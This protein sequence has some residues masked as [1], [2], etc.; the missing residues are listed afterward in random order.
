LVS[1]AP[2]SLRRLT[3]D[4]AEAFRAL[5]LE[6]F[7]L[8]PECFRYAPED[9]AHL[10]LDHFARRLDAD[11]VLGL[12]DAETLVGVGGLMAFAGVKVAHKALLYGMYLRAAFRGRGGADLLMAELLA[13][14]DA[15]Y[16]IV[17]LTVM[18]ANARARR[19]YE[20]W[21]FALYGVEPGSVKDADGVLR[22]EAL[23]AR[24][25]LG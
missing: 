15:H 22:D 4:D 2:L 12:F 3:R 18:A 14:A 25:R 6:G 20:R 8:D 23:M 7:S 17:T 5:R 19:F 1:A 9:E 13:H 16:E 11:F 24:R 21:G 10:P